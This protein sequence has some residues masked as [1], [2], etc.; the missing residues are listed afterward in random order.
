MIFNNIKSTIII[1]GFFLISMTQAVQAQQ[2]ATIKGGYIMNVQ[3]FMKK[4]M[5]NIFADSPEALRIH[6][7]AANQKRIGDISISLAGG[8]LI[9]G[10]FSISHG[11]KIIDSSDNLLELTVNTMGGGVFVVGG[12]LLVVGGVALAT[13]SLVNYSSSANSYKRA[14]HEYSWSNFEKNGFDRDKVYIDANISSS[15]V[16]LTYNF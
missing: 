13:I 10:I 3:V 7:L 6:N 14:L 16:S 11:Q 15:G 1:L 12:Y 9:S 2:I 8:A 4:D 5:K